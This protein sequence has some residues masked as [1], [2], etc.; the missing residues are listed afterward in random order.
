MHT[1]QKT[2]KRCTHKKNNLNKTKK[3]LEDCLKYGLT[4]VYI[5]SDG[6]F[7]GKKGNYKENDV[8]NSLNH[9]GKIKKKIEKFITKKFNNY[10]IIRVSKVFGLQKNDKT[11][12]T[13]ILNEMKKKRKVFFSDDQFFLQFMLM[14]CANIFIF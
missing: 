4:P 14:I 6:V 7:D 3:L 5:S 9:Y 1:T 10:L 2:Q 8:L 12:I 13:S 11:L